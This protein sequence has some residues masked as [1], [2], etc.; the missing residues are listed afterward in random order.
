MKIHFSFTVYSRFQVLY[1]IL[2]ERNSLSYYQCYSQVFGYFKIIIIL[3]VHLYLKCFGFKWIDLLIKCVYK[4][5]TKL[6]NHYFT[7]MNIILYIFL[8]KFTQLSSSI[9]TSKNTFL[10]ATPDLRPCFTQ[11]A[12]LI[13]F[14]K[15]RPLIFPYLLIYHVSRPFI[16]KIV[17]WPSTCYPSPLKPYSLFPF[18]ISKLILNLDNHLHL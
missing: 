12:M 16:L 4:I 6:G 14:S 8:L 17:P 1:K 9:F 7:D 15:T 10:F 2:T 11:G 3:K 18:V 5:T 13:M